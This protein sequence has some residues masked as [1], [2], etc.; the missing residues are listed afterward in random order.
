MTYKTNNDCLPLVSVGMYD[1]L[2]SPDSMYSYEFDRDE[3]CRP[4]SDWDRF[5]Y[6]KYKEHVGKIAAEH[7]KSIAEERLVGKGYGIKAVTSDGGIDSPGP[8]E[9]YN[10]RTDYLN[11]DIEVDENFVETA[12]ANLEKWDNGGEVAKYAEEHF[13]SYDG[14]NSFVPWRL[15]EIAFKI[16]LNED[17]NR[18]V[19]IYACLCLVD[20]GYFHHDEWDETPAMKEYMHLVEDI[21]DNAY[22]DDFL[23]EGE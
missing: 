14:F 19:G 6:A 17:I 2:L 18:I 23:T 16:K 20:S 22:F 12:V 8:Y 21:Q 4:D 1:S 3:D 7:V 9:G 10:F 11:I 15:S 13:K 5:D